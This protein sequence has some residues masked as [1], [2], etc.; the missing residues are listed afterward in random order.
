MTILPLKIAVAWLIPAIGLYAATVYAADDASP[1][2][3]P[4][5]RAHGFIA[6]EA[7]V[8]GGGRQCLVQDLV[9]RSAIDLIDGQQRGKPSIVVSFRE[10][11]NVDLD[12][13]GHLVTTEPFED[14]SG[15]ALSQSHSLENASNRARGPHDITIRNGIVRTP[16][17]WGVSIYLGF[18]KDYRLATDYG[19]RA[20]APLP[21]DERPMSE[22]AHRSMPIRFINPWNYQPETHFTIDNLNIKSGGRG[23]IMTG[24][25]NVLRNSTIE[26][27][28]D[29]AVYLYGP[30]SVVEGNTIIIHQKPD[31]PY[32]SERSAALK[33][34][35]ADGAIIRNNRF[36]VKDGPLGLFKGQA[37]VA[38]NLLES[39]D[40]V[41]EN[42]IIEG[43]KALVRK[44]AASTTIEHGNELK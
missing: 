8:R 2:C 7:V 23:V 30:D 44:D 4:V 38:I 43:A 26:V 39:H 28:S 17:K 34:R 11:S 25:K 12:L 9:Q 41:I 22:Q 21:E 31:Y 42:N 1:A 27:D 18:F 10:A 13:Q 33:L 5:K 36:I 35:D 15:I 19:A 24:A 3:E 37:E 16:G 29:T 20:Y 14:G 6:V 40:V 32:P